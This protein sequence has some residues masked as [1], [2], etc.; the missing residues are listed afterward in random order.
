MSFWS[1]FELWRDPL[2]ADVV[3][4]VACAALGVFLVLRKLSFV[5]ATVPQA[6]GVGV[7]LALLLA[8]I[9]GIEANHHAHASLLAH[10][11]R[12]RHGID[13]LR[14]PTNVAR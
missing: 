4:A 2:T 6:A 12:Q 7:T 1:A 3:S 13:E 5:A 11:P 8:G 14:A 9:L 10:G